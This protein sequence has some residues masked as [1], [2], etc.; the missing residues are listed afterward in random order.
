M[1]APSSRVASA[2]LRRCGDPGFA[3][4]FGG[5]YIRVPRKGCANWSGGLPFRFILVAGIVVPNHD[6]MRAP[7][8]AQASHARPSTRLSRWISSARAPEPREDRTWADE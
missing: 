4:P 2:L 7:F 8:K 1:N 3:P 6:E 5:D